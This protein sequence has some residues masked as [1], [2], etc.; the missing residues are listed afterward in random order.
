[1]PKIQWDGDKEPTFTHFYKID[2]REFW[3]MLE[4]LRTNKKRSHN[5]VLAIVHA[6]RWEYVP[7]VT[8]SVILFDRRGF[9]L[10]TEVLSCQNAPSAFLE[11]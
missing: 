1:M 5:E 4:R 11:R 9:A 7:F 6:I 2:S 10:A 3:I 8:R